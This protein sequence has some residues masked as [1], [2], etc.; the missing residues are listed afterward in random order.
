M[1]LYAYCLTASGARTPDHV[2]GL[3]GQTVNTITS[4]R[5]A[6]FVSNVSADPVA[7]TKQNA[8]DHQKVVAAMLEQTSPLPFRFGIVVT[9]EQLMNYLVSREEAL[10]EKLKAVHGCVEMSVKVIWQKPGTRQSE[11]TERET[12]EGPGSAFLRMKRSE[13]IGSQHLI[14]QANKIAAW[15]QNQLDPVI[16]EARFTVRPAERLVVAADCLVERNRMNSYRTVVD[17]ARS[18]QGDLRFLMSG[19]WAPYSFANINL[20][21]KTHF[22]VS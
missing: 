16:R 19:P 15:L 21:F 18:E 20:E 5:L 22:G 13:I 4:N 17:Q 11:Q 6:A 9:E 3:F 7:V 2:T 10:L 12:S 8:L 14:D 1:K